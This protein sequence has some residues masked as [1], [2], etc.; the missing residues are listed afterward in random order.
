MRFKKMT[1]FTE[2]ILSLLVYKNFA[3]TLMDRVIRGSIQ[4]LAAGGEPGWANPHAE[5]LRAPWGPGLQSACG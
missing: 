1:Q 2:A 5:G 3:Q 4:T